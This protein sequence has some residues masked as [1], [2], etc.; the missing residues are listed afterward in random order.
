MTKNKKAVIAAAVVIAALLWAAPDYSD[1]RTGETRTYAAPEPSAP[2]M[3]ASAM[4]MASDTIEL[5]ADVI[6]ASISQEG[7][8]LALAIIVRNGTSKGRAQQ[9]GDNFVRMAKTFGPDSN[10]SKEIGRGQYDYLVGVRSVDGT[11]IARGAKLG[12]SPRITW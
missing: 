6:D 7:E 2:A 10:P 12:F 4:Q 3:S 9:L 11:D 5:E 1:Q 8:K